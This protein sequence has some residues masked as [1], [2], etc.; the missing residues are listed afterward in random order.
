MHWKVSNYIRIEVN[1]RKSKYCRTSLWG[2]VGV[3]FLGFEK[4]ALSTQEWE[5]I[6]RIHQ[7]IWALKFFENAKGLGGMLRIIKKVLTK[8]LPV[9]IFLQKKNPKYQ[10]FLF[11]VAKS[12]ISKISLFAWGL[13]SRNK[14][15]MFV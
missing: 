12:I 2:G 6:A 7:L 3:V 8:Q 5:Y 15:N 4:F 1:G 13:R 14:R 9:T 10:I 11:G